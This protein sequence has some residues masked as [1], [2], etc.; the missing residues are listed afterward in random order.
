M[1]PLLYFGLQ[2]CIAAAPNNGMQP[3]VSQLA[4]HRELG[5]TAVECAASDAG[6]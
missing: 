5:R 1:W 3:T 2:H 6:R 4:C